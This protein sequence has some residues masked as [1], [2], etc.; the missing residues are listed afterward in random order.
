LGL[1]SS[2][3]RSG[4]IAQRALAIRGLARPNERTHPGFC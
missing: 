2:G 4:S 1:A 3:G